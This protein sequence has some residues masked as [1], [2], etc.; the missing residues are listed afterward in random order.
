VPAPAALLLAAVVAATALGP[1]RAALTRELHGELA[2]GCSASELR[3]IVH[4]TGFAK[5]GS[6]GSSSVVLADIH[7]SCLCG[8]VNCPYLV[9]R[10]DPDGASQVLLST[11]AYDVH[12]VGNAQPLP[13]LHET[14][15]D[16]ALVSV[17]TTDAFRGA[18][19]IAVATSRVRGDTGATKPDRMPIRFAPGASSAVLT[20]RISAGWY[21]TYTF[22]ARRGQRVTIASSRLPP[23]T[24][25][26]LNPAGGE[27][28]IETAGTTDRGYRATIA[29][30]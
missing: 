8:N 27:R 30:R 15:H 24:T 4:D 17:E 3:S 10:L 22:A 19:Y 2:S 16:S 23:G 12:A 1:A 26:S 7:G 14:A 29:I 21:D 11:Y 5:L 25:F 20:G 18:N 6:L 13:D 9:L 28:S